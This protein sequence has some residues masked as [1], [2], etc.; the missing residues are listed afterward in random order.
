MGEVNDEPEATGAEVDAGG[1]V[2][3]TDTEAPVGTGSDFVYK[4]KSEVVVSTTSA[5]AASEPPT[6]AI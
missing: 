1:D 6:S 5:R 2:A 3:D 4:H